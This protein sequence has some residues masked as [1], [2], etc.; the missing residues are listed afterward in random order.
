MNIL[1]YGQTGSGKTYT[2]FNN[3][4]AQMALETI[5]AYIEATPDR[6]F[7]VRVAYF[8]IHNEVINDLAS[9]KK[10]LQLTENLKVRV[11]NS[12]HRPESLSRTSPRPSVP[13][14]SR[15]STSSLMVINS[16]TR[17]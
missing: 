7:M 12:P 10:N 2:L 11:R 17:A 16:S 8:E 15:G 13:S 4:V 1:C 9:E 14:L 3:G 6:E 5:F